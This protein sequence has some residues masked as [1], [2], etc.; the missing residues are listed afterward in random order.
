MN[1]KCQ[2]CKYIFQIEKGYG[3][4]TEDTIICPHCNTEINILNIE[5]YN[6]QDDIEYIMTNNWKENKIIKM[7]INSARIF[8]A[9]TIVG[10]MGLFGFIQAIINKSWGPNII[11][12]FIFLIIGCY[13]ILM[14]FC[15]E[16]IFSI[17]KNSFVFTGV[18]KIGFKKKIDWNNVKEIYLDKSILKRG[19][20]YY[21]I[22]KGSKKIKINI[23][24]LDEKVREY[25]LNTLR[26]LR[27]RKK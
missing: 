25:L 16:I 1:I 4:E 14:Y 5:E 11:F 17:G 7:S 13:V 22:L 10:I 19:R 24:W 3:D 6:E 2:K 15:G 18:G 12:Y 20:K 26:D 9:G 23:T 21:I 8:F 27:Y